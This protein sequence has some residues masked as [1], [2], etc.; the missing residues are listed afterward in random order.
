MTEYNIKS[1]G[2]V[3]ASKLVLGNSVTVGV[4]DV[5]LNWTGPGYSA[6][7]SVPV[8]SNRWELPAASSGTLVTA[9]GVETLKNKTILSS[10]G[11]VVD[12]NTLDGAPVSSIPAGSLLKKGPASWEA[13]SIGSSA[14][15]V[16]AGD[17]AR[18]SVAGILRVKSNPGAG[19]FSTIGAAIAAATLGSVIEI[20]PGTYTETIDI[21]EGVTLV[22]GGWDA[23]TI[24]GNIIVK[25]EVRNVTLASD[26][27]CQGASA[28]LVNCLIDA[29]TVQDGAIASV[30]GCKV[31]PTGLVNTAGVGIS[32]NNA[33]AII[34][35]THVGV[36]TV[37]VEISGNSDVNVLDCVVENCDT[38]IKI[39]DSPG[40]PV[41][42]VS[43]SLFNTNNVVNLNPLAKLNVVSMADGRLN[44]AGCDIQE[45][46]LG[47]A[48]V[49]CMDGGDVSVTTGTSI[50]VSAGYGYVD[51]DGE[52]RKVSWGETN[53]TLTA[54]NTH[55]IYVTPAGV[56]S[57]TTPPPAGA[58][59]LARV[60]CGAESVDF[61][62]TQKMVARRGFNEYLQFSKEVLGPLVHSGCV[63]TVDGLDVEIGSGVYYYLNNR[64]EVA[65]QA[66]PARWLAFYH[67]AG[68]FVSEAQSVIDNMRY[69]NLTS[70]VD[71]DTDRYTKH[72]L[73]VVS[74]E[75]YLL[76]YGQE[77]YD[78]LDVAISAPPP[79]APTYFG[80][81]VMPLAGLVV[82]RGST[83]VHVVD[84]RPSLC[85]SAINFNSSS[86]VFDKN[87]N[88]TIM[89]LLN[90]NNYP[91]ASTDN[92]LVRW[93][94]TAGR[95]IKD[96]SAVL[97]DGGNLIVA[98]SINA[99]GGVD[100]TSIMATG[101]TIGTIITDSVNASYADVG[102]LVAS[103]LTVSYDLGVNN[104]SANSIS[105]ET[106]TSVSSNIG[107]AAATSLT[108]DSLT[109]TSAGF[110][111]PIDAPNFPGGSTVRGVGVFVDSS[112]KKI[113]STQVTIDSSD[114][115]STP[116]SITSEEVVTSE[117][118][119]TVG[120]VATLNSTTGTISALTSNSATVETLSAA[121]ATIDNLNISTISPDTINTNT[122][123]TNTINTD[124]LNADTATINTVGSSNLTA[125]NATFTNPIN[126]PNFPASSTDNAVVR[127]DG[128]TGKLLQDSTATLDDDGNLST[129]G[130]IS[131]AAVSAPS[132]AVDTLVPKDDD[133]V[134]INSAAS[135]AGEL[136]VDGGLTTGSNV[137][138]NGN[139]TVTG[140]TLLGNVVASGSITAE[141]ITSSTPVSAPNFPSAATDNAVVRFDGTG[142]NVVQ[143]SV[144][145]IADD[146]AITTPAGISARNLN[147]VHADG[148]Q[149]AFSIGI[150]GDTNPGARFTVGADGIVRWGD[151]TTVD[152]QLQRSAAQT[153]LLGNTS[154]GAATL[155]LT[156][157]S[158]ITWSGSPNGSNTIN[159]T[160]GQVYAG[161]LNIA[162]NGSLAWK[163]TGSGNGGALVNTADGRW[164]FRNSAG[165]AL[166][167]T[168]DLNKVVLSTKPPAIPNSPISLY[169]NAL[170]VRLTDESR[171][172]IHVKGSGVIY[173]G[174]GS[175]M[176][177]V[178]I[179][180]NNAGDRLQAV[181]ILGGIADF[182]CNDLSTTT[183][184]AISVKA[185]SAEIYDNNL[186]LPPGKNINWV[187]R[188]TSSAAGAL[189]NTADGKWELQD[190][191]GSTSTT[192]LKVG[193]INGL[194]V[195]NWILDT[196]ASDFH[197]VMG[198]VRCRI[199]IAKLTDKIWYF[200]IG[201]AT[202][203]AT[204]TEIVT[205]GTGVFVNFI[206]SI[207]L[208][209]MW[210]G[211][212]WASV[213]FS[214]SGG[215][216]RIR[217]GLSIPL[218]SFIQGNTYTWYGVSFTVSEA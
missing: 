20:G 115:I 26:I 47:T 36:K 180:C 171:D 201:E 85:G 10:D 112:G 139:L 19:E 161:G 32:V 73:Y 210:V 68:V 109:A 88:L 183:I 49:G 35:N 90:S 205:F 142:G 21:P 125:T 81:G 12:A 101:A 213:S 169:E 72:V 206:R 188:T 172:R 215:Y 155:A 196:E 158:S 164:E 98:G 24:S 64:F 3:T 8:G 154:G 190:S 31:V 48:T 193:L 208:A 170:I 16:A 110:A 75:K 76:V 86:A 218:G 211:N 59:T 212:E 181:N 167:S 202:F 126:A 200:E 157:G 159:L 94:G 189:V 214:S 121:N 78:D 4:D 216:L 173:F 44:L 184:N 84:M 107:S 217:P 132:A 166:Y 1:A 11:N 74:P 185:D 42:N 55:Y 27:T 33:S 149:T 140:D 138:I 135:I 58:I 134:T 199:R 57:T 176:P 150:N 111:N 40:S 120:T 63:V 194:P 9:D 52:L 65:G 105:V 165:S 113:E 77:Q 89:G 103:N 22:G 46:I 122:I 34:R 66:A 54:Q 23:V 163:D 124:I 203:T 145:T 141:S 168:L 187:D 82:K 13:V 128:A 2:G 60:H 152:V 129:V 209:Q 197:G 151:G 14:G 119:A 99:P 97:D 17:D 146:G 123:N 25:G 100:T 71:L 6:T 30:V 29:V 177:A 116:G 18:F 53:F 117:L 136:E 191:S 83:E 204:K 144:V 91:D 147:L 192:S 67:N 186:Y 50:S 43:S 92:A 207:S 45:N 133:K 79:A 93:D 15:T 175:G 153:L 130:S 131:A 7:L 108:T 198:D 179:T 182:E 70:R 106:L 114:N 104:M 96:S 160:G 61:I 37:G 38:G 162:P 69:D 148:V 127:F 5:N 87:G 118:S 28:R 195:T 62:D 178:G 156:S 39:T 41:V 95:V 80:G 143:D 102:N 51:V 56:V 174:R 137:T